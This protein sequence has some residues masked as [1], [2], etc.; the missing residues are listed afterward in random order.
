[1]AILVLLASVLATLIP[2]LI[3]ASTLRWIDRYEREPTPLVIA[4]FLW[5]ATPAVIIA[6]VSEIIADVP[7]GLFNLSAAK[8]ISSS[9]IAPVIEELAKGIFVF[10]V[11]WFFQ[12]EFDDPIDGIVY[13]ALVGFGFA[14][15]ENVFYFLGAWVAG[16]WGQW[17]VLVVLRAFLFGMNHAF[18]TSLTGLGLGLAR[19]TAPF[20]ARVIF[21]LAGL[22]A[23]ILFHSI[24][25]L[26]AS[27]AATNMLTLGVSA[28][29]DWGGVLIVFIIIVIGWAF[30]KRWVT[31]ELQEEIET[32]LID[33]REYAL[34][35]SY[36]AR[37]GARLG[38]WARGDWRAAQ[39]TGRLAQLLAE[40]AFKKY[41][42]RQR[43]QDYTSQIRA[44]RTEIALARGGS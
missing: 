22:G 34:A 14:L 15:T 6:A 24:H 23:A 28:L 30:E 5:G 10:A 16:G 33:V 31:E 18:F 17:T 35:R 7:L 36:R 1:M 41:Q 40:L 32:G 39:R 9:A 43:G 19:V 37:L 25:N 29:S 42:M 44:L 12:R 13:G 20:F 26:G 38:A 8:L 2:T 21:A 3:F 4:A 11:Y 27:L